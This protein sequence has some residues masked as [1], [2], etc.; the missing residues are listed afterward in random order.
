MGH[1]GIFF[2]PYKNEFV[3]SWICRLARANGLSFRH[4]MMN[5]MGHSLHISPEEH[6]V[7]RLS[8]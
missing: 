1:I 5:Y 3:Y 7:S 2:T 6:L 8:L 4:F